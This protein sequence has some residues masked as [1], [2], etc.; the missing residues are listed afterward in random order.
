MSN[1]PW[2]Y[3][4]K[5]RLCLFGNVQSDGKLRL[6]KDVLSDK[7]PYTAH[8][9]MMSMRASLILLTLFFLTSCRKDEETVAPV[10][11]SIT[12]SVYASGKILAENQYVVYPV[13]SGLLVQV[14]RS[15]GD[16]VAEGDTLFVVDNVTS[17]LNSANAHALLDLNEKLGRSGS[18]RL[19]EM[20]IAV[21][22][23]KEKYL[24][25]STQCARQ[26]RLWQKEI[27]SRLEL[28]QKELA[29]QVSKEQWQAAAARLDQTKLQLATE[30]RRSEINYA[31]STKGSSDFVIRSKTDGII[32]DVYYERNEL[33][34]PQ[35]ALAVVGNPATFHLELQV[36]EYDIAKI[37]GGQQVLITM[38]IH[39]GEIFEGVITSVSP[40]MNERTGSFKVEADFVVPPDA[41]FPNSTVEANIVLQRKESAL[42]IPR[43]FVEDEKFVYISENDRIE[44][45]TGLKNYDQV[46]VLS[47]LEADQKIYLPP[48]K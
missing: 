32:Y 35:T 9:P 5:G 10:K 28:E 43:R 27:G 18:S 22:T 13:V 44:I 42:I 48:V 30:I 34:T 39:K 2:I 29:F 40:I 36:D 7:S 41:L 19:E 16:S 46:E 15:P 20:E 6:F 26:T 12:E 45:V 4:W 17:N 31:I 11:G 38:D 24:F 23:A 33:V 1:H 47:G 8:C 3:R 14:L 21:N 25:D 37:H